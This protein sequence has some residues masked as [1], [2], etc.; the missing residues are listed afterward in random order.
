MLYAFTQL[1]QV[2]TVDQCRSVYYAYVQS[3]LLYGNLVWGGASCN[4]LEPLAVTQRA[5]I[6][7]ILKKGPRY[8]TNMLFSEFRVFNIRQLFI[9]TVLMFVRQNISSLF[10]EVDHSYETRNRSN[11]GYQ[12]PRLN[13]S[14]ETGHS[15]YQIHTLYRNLPQ[16]LR[17]KEGESISSYKRRISAW[18]TQIDLATLE[19]I[20]SSSYVQTRIT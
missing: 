9:K 18:L 5:L 16:D 20:I 10:T 6:K 11:F 13:F 4:V 7:I 15:Y 3:L 8:P 17:S 12:I 14:F 19:A 2:L 1:A